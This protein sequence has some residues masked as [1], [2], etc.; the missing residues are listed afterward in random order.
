M[1]IK[2][3]KA[4]KVAI[5]GAGA[6]GSTFAYALAQS[7]VVD[8]IAL[9]D[10]NQDLVKGQVLD[11]SHGLPFF[12]AIRIHEGDSADYHDAD[13]IVITAGAKQQPDESRLAL[14]ERNVAIVKKIALDIIAQKSTAVI[15]MVSNPVDILTYTMQKQ[16]GWAPGQ[17][18]GS[19]TVLDSARFRY[20]LGKYL[21]V[22]SHSV[23]G[24]ILGEHGDSEFAAWSMT[25]VGGSP[26]DQYCAANDK[27]V[28]WLT[29]RERIVDEVKS[30][31]YHIINYKG[32]TNFAIGLA[33]T[34]IVTA[35]LR[36][37][38]SVLSVS[39]LLSGEYGIQDVC[40]SVP[41]V[42]SQKGVERIIEG[43][44]S[45]SEVLALSGSAATLKKLLLQHE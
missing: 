21:G 38:R 32:A 29:E 14:L 4:R 43:N 15:L 31:G 2:E 27:C 33:L 18:I 36:N 37:Q 17:V 35:V 26:I 28:D 7:G 22:D 8:D 23:H 24:Y 30:S 13:I 42:V 6:V 20:L 11:L 10:F 1:A 9:I 40:L 5:V 16:L 44:L 25:Y 12:P 3:W 39:T 45:P 19:G 34:Q 41:C